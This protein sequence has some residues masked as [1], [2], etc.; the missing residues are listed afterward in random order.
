MVPAGRRRQRTRDGSRVRAPFFLGRRDA[1]VEA[2]AG[3]A[4]A[5]T[6]GAAPS[7]RIGVPLERRPFLWG[8]RGFGGMLPLEWLPEYGPVLAAGVIVLGAGA[9]QAGMRLADRRRDRTNAL[10]S[11]YY[12]LRARLHDG[13]VYDGGERKPRIDKPFIMKPADLDRLRAFFFEKGYPLHPELHYY[14]HRTM[15]DADMRPVRAK[16]RYPDLEPFLDGDEYFADFTKLF[17]ETWERLDAR[18][19]RAAFDEKWGGVAGQ[20][21]KSRPYVFPT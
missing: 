2:L 12:E 15:S 14:Y 20:D 10:R 6:P 11:L 7:A 21:G 19:K 3:G 9:L 18:D 8:P 17:R 4:P 1:L 13:S 5:A 16:G